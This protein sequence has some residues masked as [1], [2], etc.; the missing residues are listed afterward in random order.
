[1]AMNE[2]QLYRKDLHQV[3]AP[4]ATGAHARAHPPAR[5]PARTCMHPYTYIMYAI[6]KISMGYLHTLCIWIDVPVVDA[7]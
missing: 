2:I 6:D 7:W 4:A 1:M 3:P 5:P